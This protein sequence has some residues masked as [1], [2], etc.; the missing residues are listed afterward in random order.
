MCS[1]PKTSVR[2]G[3]VFLELWI[4]SRSDIRTQNVAAYLIE[5]HTA[6]LKTDE[7]ST[8]FGN[9]RRTTVLYNRANKISLSEYV[10]SFVFSKHQHSIRLFGSRF[11]KNSRQIMTPNRSLKPLRQQY[12]LA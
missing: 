10:M 2:V 7:A 11:S 9:T 3:F 12:V 8:I 1:G 5:V 4:F 6:V